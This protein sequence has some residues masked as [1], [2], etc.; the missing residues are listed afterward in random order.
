MLAR[1]STL[2]EVTC[3]EEEGNYVLFIFFVC[4]SLLVNLAQAVCL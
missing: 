3:A 2:V 1:L 4:L